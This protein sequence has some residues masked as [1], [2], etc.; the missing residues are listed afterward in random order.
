MDKP[1]A[2]SDI[3]V[4]D[5]VTLSP[6][7]DVLEAI[8]LLLEHH[9]SGAPVVDDQGRLLGVLTELDCIRRLAEAASNGIPAQTVGLCMSR[10]VA[11]VREST[12]LLTI[13]DLFRNSR[14]RRL[15]LLRG[16]RL[17]GQITRRDLLQAFNTVLQQT[18]PTERGAAFL[19]LSALHDSRDHA[20]IR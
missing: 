10:D 13:S 19:Y 12:D 1:A 15:P 17:V 16:D 3:M 5:L 7:T 20:P 9:I 11:T 2:A 6:E 8:D 18:P 4:S 14:V